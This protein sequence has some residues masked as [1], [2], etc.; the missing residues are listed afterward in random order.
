MTHLCFFNQTNINKLVVLVSD[1]KTSDWDDFT[2]IKPFLYSSAWHSLSH[3]NN[4]SFAL[5]YDMSE[6]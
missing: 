2:P 5:L 6:V 1:L 4:C 3:P